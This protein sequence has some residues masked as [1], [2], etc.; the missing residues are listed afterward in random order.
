[1]QRSNSGPTT[2]LTCRYSLPALHA[3]SNL[4][5]SFQ[6]NFELFG[7][8]SRLHGHDYQ[9]DVSIVGPVDSISGLIFGRD[10]L[11]RVIRERLIDPFRGQ[12]LSD[13]FK[14][15]TGEALAVEIYRILAPGFVSPIALAS[16]KVA[17]TAKNSFRI[18]SR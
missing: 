6:E 13:H 15:T 10:E 2:V 7:P 14:Q 8:C 11:D 5:L 3:L 16:V 4:S 9:I 18:E 1:M 12:N 17:E